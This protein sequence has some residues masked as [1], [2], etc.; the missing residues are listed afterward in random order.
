MC[1]PDSKFT[2]IAEFSIL[3]V[4]IRGAFFSACKQKRQK[5]FL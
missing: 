3:W 1:D 4:G 2:F 5:L